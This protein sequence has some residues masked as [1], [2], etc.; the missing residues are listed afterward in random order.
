MSALMAEI[1]ELY[2][3]KEPIAPE[4]VAAVRGTL[5]SLIGHQGPPPP[6]SFVARYLAI[7]QDEPEVVMQHAKLRHALDRL[8]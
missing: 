6:D 3:S 8:Y 7:L 4:A 1:D 5:E 2:D